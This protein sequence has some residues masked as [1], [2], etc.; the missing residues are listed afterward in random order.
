MSLA[1]SRLRPTFL[2]H[3]ITPETEGRTG[4]VLNFLGPADAFEA[5]GGDKIYSHA[6]LEHCRG[7]SN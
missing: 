5:A 3:W 2:L 6:A 7:F 4:V 1:G